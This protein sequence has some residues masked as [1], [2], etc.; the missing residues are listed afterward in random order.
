MYV[1][2]T[3]RLIMLLVDLQL[4]SLREAKGKRVWVWRHAWM[5]CARTV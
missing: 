4:L 5:G 3:L 1:S 2:T